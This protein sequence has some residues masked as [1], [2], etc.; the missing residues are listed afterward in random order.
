MLNGICVAPIYKILFN[1][2]LGTTT[3][4]SVIFTSYLCG[5]VRLP[6]PP[7]GRETMVRVAIYFLLFILLIFSRASSAEISW[8]FHLINKTTVVTGNNVISVYGAL[9]NSLISD[10]TLVISAPCD[11]CFFNVTSAVLTTDPDIF[12]YYTFDEGPLGTQDLS[13]ILTGVSV[14][15]GNYIDFLFYS[16]VPTATPIPAGEYRIEYNSLGLNVNNFFSFN[17]GGSLIVSVVPEP[18]TYW[19]FLAGLACLYV[20]FRWRSA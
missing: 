9:E 1:Q 15:P 8:S 5:A 13:S 10:E 3:M 7:S 4:R 12:N 16:L 19:L 2:L 18:T 17:D 6:P 20:A 14:S 11:G